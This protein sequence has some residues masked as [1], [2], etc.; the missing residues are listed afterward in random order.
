MD[1]INVLARILADHGLYTCTYAYGV[2][3]TDC[4]GKPY[5]WIAIDPDGGY[6]ITDDSGNDCTFFN[7][8]YNWLG[9]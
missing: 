2:T 6:Y 5:A 1:K 8:I 4:N 9:Y 7:S 3:C